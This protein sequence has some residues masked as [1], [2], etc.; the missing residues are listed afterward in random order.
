MKHA[1]LR[2]WRLL[3][4]AWCFG[5][6]RSD[7]DSQLLSPPGDATTPNGSLHSIPTSEESENPIAIATEH[8]QLPFATFI[9]CVVEVAFDGESVPGQASTQIAWTESGQ[10]AKVQSAAQSLLIKH[11]GKTS[12]QARHRIRRRA[13]IDVFKRSGL[14]EPQDLLETDITSTPAQWDRHFAMMVANHC[15]TH[16]IS[17]IQLKTRLEYNRSV[18]AYL[19]NDPSASVSLRACDAVLQSTEGVKAV[20]ISTKKEDNDWEEDPFL[21]RT[22][23]RSLFPRRIIEKIIRELPMPPS[24]LESDIRE[25]I[26]H[27][28]DNGI[29]L[30][31]C[32]ILAGK[33]ECIFHFVKSKISDSDLPLDKKTLMARHEWVQDAVTFHG[34]PQHQRMLTVLDFALMSPETSVRASRHDDLP[35][36]FEKVSTEG[37]YFYV[38]PD[39]V[40]PFMAAKMVK[41]GVGGYGVVY[42][43]EIHP[44][45]HSFEENKFALK[46]F[47]NHVRIRNF[48]EESRVL[49]QLARLNNPS[50]VVPLASW[51]QN[52]EFYMLMPLANRNLASYLDGERKLYRT[53]AFCLHILKQLQNIASGI[54]SI[55]MLKVIVTGADENLAVNT[56]ANLQKLSGYHHD[57]KPANILV[58]GQQTENDYS[59]E[60]WKINDFGTARISTIVSGQDSRMHRDD[61][62]ADPSGVDMEYGAPDQEIS[63]IGGR[64][65]PYD[66][67]AFGCIILE[68]L[69]W[70]FYEEEHSV[71]TFGYARW[72]DGVESGSIKHSGSKIPLQETSSS[73]QL[74][75]ND[76]NF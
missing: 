58:Y 42:E 30:L 24:Y 54:Q 6:I 27:V 63:G 45:Y 44:E 51:Q 20:I 69:V 5:S 32:C 49:T 50:I 17:G 55:H 34:F 67:W 15:L 70:I 59:G 14:H 33:P 57:L 75:W 73:D 7:T 56:P 1:R 71:G 4:S 35:G 66:I 28:V 52:E 62:S 53:P 2:P 10:Y 37:N 3:S 26:K 39:V 38:K 61:N 8:Q 48:D 74:W 60:S 43:V 68:V 9:E 23:A 76:S 22:K 36:L 40:V 72:M 25:C 21:P 46:I 19:P 29:H 65:R 11:Y 41:D 64:S 12:L 13:H 16:G 47:Q 31:A 18:L